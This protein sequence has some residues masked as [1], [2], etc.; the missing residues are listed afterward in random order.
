MISTFSLTYRLSSK[1]LNNRQKVRYFNLKLILVLVKI[2]L[3][4]LVMK[5][6]TKYR[7]MHSKKVKEKD[8]NP[9]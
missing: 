6:D 2:V 9:K 5:T 3:L 7:E 4:K 8:A 1:S